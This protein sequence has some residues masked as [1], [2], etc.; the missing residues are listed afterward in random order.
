MI[1]IMIAAHDSTQSQ[2]AVMHT[3]P[4][5]I[6]LVNAWK[7]SL[8]SFFYPVMYFLVKKV[9]RPPEDGARIVFIIALSAD[10]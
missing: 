7:S 4:A 2:E 5:R 8:T 1:P 3:S 9:K 6:P 10:K